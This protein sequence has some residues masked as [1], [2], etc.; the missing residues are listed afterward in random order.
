MGNTGKISHGMKRAGHMNC[1]ENKTAIRWSGMAVVE[2][3][4]GTN[5]EKPNRGSLAIVERVLRKIL[6]MANPDFEGRFPEVRKWW[7]EIDNSGVPQR[8]LG[9]AADGEAI[10]A[11]PIGENFGF[12][13]DSAMTFNSD[14]H[15][16]VSETA[17]HSAWTTFEGSWATRTSNRS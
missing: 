15:K 3:T 6:P 5:F 8:E 2:T 11:C 13:T 9:F 16:S 10:V 7:I 1:C 14:E 4:L 17:F 12:W